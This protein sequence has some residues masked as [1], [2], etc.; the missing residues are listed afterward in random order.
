MADTLTSPYAIEIW[1]R[2]ISIDFLSE[3]LDWTGAECDAVAESLSDFGPAMRVVN[4]VASEAGWSAE[5]ARERIAAASD[6][7]GRFRRASRAAIEIAGARLAE[8][9]NANVAEWHMMNLATLA[10]LPPSISVF[11]LPAAA[12]TLDSPALSPFFRLRVLTAVENR[13]LFDPRLQQAMRARLRASDNPY[14]LA[15]ALTA[16]D[17]G[18]SKEMQSFE[19]VDEQQAFL[20]AL[21][22]VLG[23]VEAGLDTVTP[24]SLETA[25]KLAF[26]LSQYRQGQKEL[27]A[28]REFTKLGIALEHR[29]YGNDD[30]KVAVSYSNFGDLL[31]RSGDLIGAREAVSRSIEIGEAFYGADHAKVG[32]RL[33]KLGGILKALNDLDGAREAYERSI[34]IGEATLEEAA[35]DLS[36]L[37]VGRDNSTILADVYG[38]NVIELVDDLRGYA[39]LL[40]AIREEAD[41]ASRCLALA[42]SIPEDGYAVGVDVVEEVAEL[43]F[44]YTI[45]LK[46][47]DKLSEARRILERVIGLRER[48]PDSLENRLGRTLAS[49]AILLQRIGDKEA[50]VPIATRLR[51]MHESPSITPNR[52]KERPEATKRSSLASRCE[53]LGLIARS[54]GDLEAAAAYF[55]RAAELTEKMGKESAARL[56]L[57]A[58]ALRQLGDID[59]ACSAYQRAVAI[60][61]RSEPRSSAQANRLDML[62]ALYRQL[63]DIEGAIDAWRK[64][65]VI[66]E[67]GGRTNSKAGTIH[68]NNF[69]RALEASGDLTQS[70]AVFERA[71]RAAAY[72]STDLPLRSVLTNFALMQRRKGDLDTAVW[73]AKRAVDLDKSSGRSPDAGVANRLANAAIVM[74]DRGDF[75]QSASMFEEARKIRIGLFG[76]EDATAKSLHELHAKARTMASTRAAIP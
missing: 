51:A 76:D 12:L 30:D 17:R 47:D 63:G 31:K 1:A 37:V 21:D 62:A 53:K 55:G 6:E 71:L 10:Y 66:D 13:V 38:D 7:A 32:M 20:D 40:N 19:S 8:S 34:R 57:R 11:L 64:A 45:F 65:T 26:R 60:G 3:R 75:L 41:N 15:V 33:A 28:A 50:L 59:S 46:H 68:L 43:L 74:F 70:E 58:S 48:L 29:R 52:A 24:R 39:A 73:Y 49:Y 14:G 72:D 25:A 36:G 44:G 16:A 61:E 67:V 54:L 35:L 42:K 23:H 22:A 27:A 56:D 4:A 5:Q 69:A 2:E 18:F 9:A